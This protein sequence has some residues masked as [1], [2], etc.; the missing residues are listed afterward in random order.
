MKVF[1]PA[2][3]SPEEWKAYHD[4]RHQRHEEER[5]E[6]PETP[7]DVVERRLMRGDPYMADH[8][9]LVFRDGR[10]V[11]ELYA[12]TMTPLSPEYETNKHLVFADAW[13]LR[14]ARR[15]GIGSGWIPVLVGLMERSGA[16]LLTVD[17]HDDA[18]H[19]FLRRLGGEPRYSEAESRLDLRELDWEMVEAWVREGQARS[20]QT[21]L[22]VY[23]DRLPEERREEFTRVS[24]ELLNTM[25]FEGLDHG[26][27]VQTTETLNEWY[28]RLDMSGS[29]HHVYLSRESDGTIS[30]M[31]DV[32]KHPYET[33][34]VHQLFTG[35]HPSARGRGLG[36]W[37]KAA[38]LLHVR[39][40]HPETMFI[41][42]EN[43]GSNASMLAINHALGFRRF[44]V[45][46]TYQLDMQQL[47][48]LV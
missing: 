18:G 2:S 22:E 17:T 1:E 33:G 24:T 46:S 13:V 37:L 39:A 30:G 23:A 28:G 34:F 15:Q 31:T 12:G 48:Q 7:D 6:D 45:T 35:V 41:T 40:T 38:M 26:D 44:R 8:R 25:P 11:A 9:W 14:E 4:F 5:P 19:A 32:V 27:I 21:R 20:P 36:K 16:R 10:A 42:T 43:A 29:R 47:A 3:A